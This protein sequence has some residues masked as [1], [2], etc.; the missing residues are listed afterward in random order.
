MRD[1]AYGATSR[2]AFACLLSA[3]V[4]SMPACEAPERPTWRRTEGPPSGQVTAPTVLTSEFQAGLWVPPPEVQNP[5]GGAMEEGYRYFTAFNCDD[6]H[7][8]RGGGGIGPPL[9]RADFIYGRRP[10]QIFQSIVQGRPNGMPAYGGKAPDEV[11]WKITAYVE[12]LATGRE[13]GDR[14]EGTAQ[15]TGRGGGG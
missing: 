15:E 9:A 1:G 6:C 10:E 14:D 12:S 5:Y 2:A 13:R 11:I 4:V 7:G 8:A 3:V